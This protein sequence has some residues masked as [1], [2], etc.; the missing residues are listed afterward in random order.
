MESNDAA[1]PQPSRFPRAGVLARVISFR[2]AVKLLARAVLELAESG[3]VSDE[4]QRKL[5]QV[6]RG[7]S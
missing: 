2:V 6:A 3:N 5:K 1:Q 7:K 4:L